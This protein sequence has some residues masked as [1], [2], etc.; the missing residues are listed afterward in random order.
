MSLND[1]CASSDWNV[2]L[3]TNA[4]NVKYKI[5][6]GYHMRGYVISVYVVRGTI[7]YFVTSERSE[8][9]TKYDIVTIYYQLNKE[10]RS[11][12]FTCERFHEYLYG[13]TGKQ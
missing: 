9:G 6:I 7:S 1:H 4:T 10:A 2:I 11:M 5:S 3:A 12:L 13:H 8:R